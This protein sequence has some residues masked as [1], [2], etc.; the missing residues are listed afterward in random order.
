MEPAPMAERTCGR[1][2]DDPS[3]SQPVGTAWPMIPDSG[4]VMLLSSGSSVAAFAGVLAVVIT[5]A[6][7]SVPRA[8]PR[9]RVGDAGFI[10]MPLPLRRTPRAARLPLSDLE[11]SGVNL[12]RFPE[13]EQNQA[14]GLDG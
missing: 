9:R 11:H 4:S 10:Q 5:V 8:A 2:V 6:S 12:P 7:A 1:V 13:S 3:K 14:T